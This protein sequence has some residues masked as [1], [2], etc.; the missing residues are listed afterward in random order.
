VPQFPKLC[1]IYLIDPAHVT[2]ECNFFTSLMFRGKKRCHKF[3]G[4][5]QFTVRWTFK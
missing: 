5:Q 4:N 1:L 3:W 2:E